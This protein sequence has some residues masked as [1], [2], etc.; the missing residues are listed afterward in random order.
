MANVT[1]RTTVKHSLVVTA[2][3]TEHF[4]HPSVTCHKIDQIS[5]LRQCKYV[6]RWQIHQRLTWMGPREME[7]ISWGSREQSACYG[8]RSSRWCPCPLLRASCTPQSKPHQK[9][10]DPECGG[11]LGDSMWAEATPG[12]LSNNVL[13]QSQRAGQGEARRQPVDTGGIQVKKI[14]YE[15]R[16]HECEPSPY[17]MRKPMPRPNIEQLMNIAG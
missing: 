17:F 1:T 16:V 8:P 5:S 3:S 12:R 13:G 4:W 11:G 2:R 10:G 9:A 7:G 6:V 15:E 14:R